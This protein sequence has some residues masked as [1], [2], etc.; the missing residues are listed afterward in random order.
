MN[1]PV[2]I[3]I[4][5]LKIL[6]IVNTQLIVKIPTRKIQIKVRLV[7]IEDTVVVRFINSLCRIIYSKSAMT[8]GRIDF[9][10]SR[11][12]CDDGKLRLIGELSVLRIQTQR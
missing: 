4:V 2:I 3:N 9:F 5:V 8:K 10:L 11:A 12:A 7:E 6:I 1:E